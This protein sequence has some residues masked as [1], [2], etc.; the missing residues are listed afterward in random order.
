MAVHHTANHRRTLHSANAVD[1][2]CWAYLACQV[3]AVQIPV[4]GQ[5]RLA[6]AWIDEVELQKS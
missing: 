3:Y 6:K 5:E 2:M 1:A 4:L